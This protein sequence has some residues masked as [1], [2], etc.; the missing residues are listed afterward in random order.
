MH[1]VADEAARAAVVAL[2]QQQAHLHRALLRFPAVPLPLLRGKVAE[3][4][5]ALLAEVLGALH[6][7]T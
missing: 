7:W 4:Q 3:H 1:R 2:H 6:R 5:A